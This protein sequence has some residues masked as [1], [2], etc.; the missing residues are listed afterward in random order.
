MTH[1]FIISYT[2]TK[3]FFGF[4]EGLPKIFEKGQT[5]QVALPFDPT[6]RQRKNQAKTLVEII[7]CQPIE[8][9]L[10]SELTELVKNGDL[11]FV[12][13]DKERIPGAW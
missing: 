8:I 10:Y 13:K 7:T 2:A 9:I 6:V 5:V 1:D 11:R 4:E 12:K 3:D